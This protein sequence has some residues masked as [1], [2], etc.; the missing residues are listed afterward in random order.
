MQ[1]AALAP[2][3]GSRGEEP[4]AGEREA[5]GGRAPVAPQAQ[6]TRE[7]TTQIPAKNR[8]RT[9]RLNRRYQRK[10]FSKGRNVP[11]RTKYR[12]QMY[13]RFNCTK[14]RMRLLCNPQTCRKAGISLPN[15]QVITGEGIN[16]VNTCS[17]LHWAC[18]IGGRGKPCTNIVR[19]PYTK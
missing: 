1:G 9:A 18:V 19:T 14:E 10:S 8:T 15:P 11:T 17:P 7:P 5:R 2:C 3:R 4:R 6:K 12:E 16:F 13:R